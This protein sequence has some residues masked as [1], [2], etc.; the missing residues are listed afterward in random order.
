MTLQASPFIGQTDSVRVNICIYLL[1]LLLF[2][3]SHLRSLPGGLDPPSPAVL[4]ARSSLPASG[5]LLMIPAVFIAFS[6][7]VLGRSPDWLELNLCFFPPDGEER[8]RQFCVQCSGGMMEQEDE[9]EV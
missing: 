2:L 6:V 8:W 3:S 4:L 9:R 1:L 5:C 7:L